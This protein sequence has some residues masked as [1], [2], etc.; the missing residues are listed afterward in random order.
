MKPLIVL[1]VAL[2]MIGC[3][4]HQPGVA[5]FDRESKD[6]VCQA[7]GDDVDQC[8]RFVADRQGYWC[9]QYATRTVLG[10]LGSPYQDQM[11]RSHCILV[12]VGE[13]RPPERVCVTPTY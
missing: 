3:A 4:T 8:G 13:S 11:A 10:Q 7:A 12:T 9:H 1:I 6:K 2:L 5:C